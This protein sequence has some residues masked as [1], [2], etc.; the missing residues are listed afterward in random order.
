MY[1]PLQWKTFVLLFLFL[2]SCSP[3]Q[4]SSTPTPKPITPHT[5]IPILADEELAEA[6]RQAQE[7]LHIWR[8]EFL[9]PKQAY[10]MTS[11]KVRFQGDAG[12][13][14]MWTEPM[15]IL[16]NVYTV[17]MVEGVTLEKGIHPERL[18]DV[19]PQ[20]IVDWML[21]EEDGTVIGGYTLRLEYERM[22]PEQQKRY[23][24]ITGYKFE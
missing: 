1:K 7:T 4:P 9:A 5:K 22:T 13:E 21:L 24:E 12:I 10:S 11:L 3:A 18:L 19:K 2:A 23:L 8:Q 20:D 17:R 16:D 6:V 15:F 14:D